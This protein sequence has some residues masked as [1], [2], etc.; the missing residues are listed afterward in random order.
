MIEVIYDFSCPEI[1]KAVHYSPALKI[2]L[3]ALPSSQTAACVVRAT[4]CHWEHPIT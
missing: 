1:T 3:D 2:S 4:I